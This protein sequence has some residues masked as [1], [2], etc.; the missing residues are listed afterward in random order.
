MKTTSTYGQNFIDSINPV[1]GRIH[2]QFNQ[3]MDTGRLSCG[4]KNKDAKIQYL[5]L[6]NLPSDKETRACFVSEKV[7]YGHQQIIVD[8]NQLL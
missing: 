7:I 6:Q 8:K 3:L 1:S 2:T 4:G 5:N